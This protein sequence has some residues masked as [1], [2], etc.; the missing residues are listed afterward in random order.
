MTRPDRRPPLPAAAFRGS[1]SF[2]YDKIGNVE[3]HAGD[4]N[5]KSHFRL[6]ELEDPEFEELACRICIQILGLGTVS[7][8]DMAT[9]LEKMAIC[10]SWPTI[11]PKCNF[12]QHWLS[13]TQGFASV[14]ELFIYN[15]LPRE[16]RVDNPFRITLFW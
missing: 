7:F 6:Y 8:W 1:S 5:L 12:K 16:N 13:I 10:R 3:L 2:A 4:G 11:Y 9:I 14:A 15:P